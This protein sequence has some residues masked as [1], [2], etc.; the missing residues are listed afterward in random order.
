MQSFPDRFLITESDKNGKMLP[1]N[2]TR[3]LKADL[4]IYFLNFRHSQK[5]IIRQINKNDSQPQLGSEFPWS[6]LYEHS[7]WWALT[8]PPRS[9]PTPPAIGWDAELRR[10]VIGC[11]PQACCW[12]VSMEITITNVSLTLGWRMAEE[13]IE[14]RGVKMMAG[15]KD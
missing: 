8:P 11:Q 9:P 12:A 6:R 7:P 14:G 13:W 2:Y 10:P 3:N 15:E 4:F 1:D 5:I